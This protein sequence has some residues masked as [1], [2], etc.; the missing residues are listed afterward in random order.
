MGKN[1]IGWFI[2]SLLVVSFIFGSVAYAAHDGGELP[3]EARQILVNLANVDLNSSSSDILALQNYNDPRIVEIGL[4]R[5][6]W[7]LSKKKTPDLDVLDG[8]TNLMLVLVSNNSISKDIFRRHIDELRELRS[9]YLYKIGNLDIRPT[10]ELFLRSVN[11]KITLS[12]KEFKE[13]Q[14]SYSDLGLLPNSLLPIKEVESFFESPEDTLQIFKDTL[15]KRIIEQPEVKEALYDL[16]F[17]TLIKGRGNSSEPPFFYLMGL[18]G[19]GKDTSAEAYVDALYNGIKGEDHLFRV[20]LQK[21]KADAWTLLGSATGYVGSSELSPF[22][23]FLVKHSAGRY[24]IVEG[25][26]GA[27]SGDYVVENPE[28]KPGMVLDGYYEPEK[29]V[30]FLNEFHNWS[31][32]A[33]AV[34]MKESLE[35]GTFKINNPGKGVSILVVPGVRFIAASNEGIDLY[36]NRDVEGARIGEPLSYDEMMERWKKIS[37]NKDLLKQTIAKTASKNAPGTPKDEQ[38]GT[39]EEILNRIHPSRMILM[40]PISPDGIR[41]IIQLRIDKINQQLFDATRGAFGSFEIK[42]TDQLIDFIKNYEYSAEDGARPV[43]DKVRSLM[44][45]TFYQALK[46]VKVHP[47]DLKNGITLDIKRNE[48]KTYNLVI[49]KGLENANELIKEQLITGTLKEKDNTPIS[50]E[51]VDNLLTLQ[52]RLKDR[53]FGADK[54]IEKISRAMLLS[55]EARHTKKTKWSDHEKATSFAF[56]GPSSTGKSEMAKALVNELF[57]DYGEQRRIDIDFNKIQNPHHMEEYIW[58]RKE[59]RNVVPSEFM[60]KYD[61]FNG[62]VLFVFEESSNTPKELLRSLYDLFRESHPKFADGK[63][64]PMTNVTIILTGNAGIEWYS[65]VPRE[66]PEDV[67]MAA[68]ARIYKESTSAN[69]KSRQTLEK[70]YPEPLINRIGEQNVIWFAPLTFTAVRELAMSKTNSYLNKLKPADGRRGW[71]V[72]FKDMNDYTKTIELFE[73]EGFLLEE[74]GASIDRYVDFALNKD[75]RALLLSNKV[76]TNSRVALSPKTDQTEEDIKKT[77]KV[78][79]DVSVEGQEKK[80]TLALDAK[81]REIFPRENKNDVIMTAIHE[82]GHEFIGRLL[83]GDKHKSDFITVIPGVTEINGEWIYYAGLRS[84]ENIERLIYTKEAVERVIAGLLGGEVA[85]TI[86]SKGQR[87]DAGKSNDIERATQIAQRAVLE[88]GL[89]PA[90]GNRSVTKEQVQSL[91]ESDRNLLNTEVKKI[92]NRSRNLAYNVLLKNREVFSELASDLIEQGEIRSEGLEAFYSKNAS[93]MVPIDNQERD[94]TKVDA[95][96]LPEGYN[97]P[98]YRKTHNVEPADFFKVPSKIANID[99]FV[100]AEKV[101]E[102]AKA[103]RPKKLP[104]LENFKGSGTSQLALPAPDVKSQDQSAGGMCARLFE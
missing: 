36:T 16:E 21:S 69:G 43:N 102:I 27:Q 98:E 51:R 18:P 85:Q 54:A 49:L 90:W 101:R 68:W 66:L 100:K 25:K 86:F 32:E 5:M 89:S 97:N 74:Q 31:S 76:P 65:N 29:A 2:H 41:K 71:D 77:G 50:D 91:S 28:W 13:R 44:E 9:L 75:L 37:Q 48:D 42:A 24:K 45:Y 55:E 30:I 83:L 78:L 88:W 14:K 95:R 46:E 53:V 4:W 23:K 3:P 19:V 10:F 39:P 22:I 40:R 61:Q 58:G 57:P 96:L 104:I 59:G 7:E 12:P 11:D 67:R 6:V 82:S 84:A 20:P 72:G 70:Y 17:E 47:S 38:I 103:R 33:K 64:R 62:D 80:L 15:D 99:D 73:K 56:L 8:L 63:D 79:V 35:K 81:K 92:L 52:E 60:R 26:G 1:F 87:N 34:V 94:S 93:R